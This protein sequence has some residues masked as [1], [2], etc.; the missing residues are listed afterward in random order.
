MEN[1]ARKKSGFMFGS[2]KPK[3][4]LKAGVA[5][6][7]TRHGKMKFFDEGGTTL[8]ERESKYIDP[9]KLEDEAND[10]GDFEVNLDKEKTKRRTNLS[11]F[12]AAFAASRARGEQE[13]KY[14]GDAKKKEGKY[15][16]AMKGE[17]KKEESPR[18]PAPA[19]A[20]PRPTAPAAARPAA[21]AAAAPIPAP[22]PATPTRSVVGQAQTPRGPEAI[23]QYNMPAQTPAAA[24]AENARLVANEQSRRQRNAAALA[25]PAKVATGY[26]PQERKTDF[27]RM[28]EIEGR[29]D[30]QRSTQSRVNKPHDF[31][32]SMAARQ[33]L[34]SPE[35]R[36]QLGAENTFL[37]N[38]YNMVGQP[39]NSATQPQYAK[40]GRVKKMAMGGLGSMG[41][42]QMGG[43]P[44]SLGSMQ[45]QP[46]MGG[47]MG[48][49]GALGG[50]GAASPIKGV[51]SMGGG[52]GAADSQMLSQ[53]GG[54][55]ANPMQQPMGGM[56]R[57][58]MG[59]GMMGRPNMGGMQGGQSG[60]MQ[61]MAKGGKVGYSKMEKE[62]VAAMKKHGVP[63][64]F[65]K[66]EEKEAKGMNKGGMAC[67]GKMKYAKGG[68]I[69]KPYVPTAADRNEKAGGDQE[70]ENRSQTR[71]AGRGPMSRNAMK[72]KAYAKGGGVESKGKTKGTMIRMASGG[73]V[74]SRAD[75]IA[76]KGKTKC[77][78]C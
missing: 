34:M 67:G 43:M 55:P 20:A 68:A 49:A 47:G 60:G 1:Q 54:G 2:K 22:R 17:G 76:S 41:G 25:A 9:T 15:S 58:P 71:G 30:S 61:A 66:Q 52:M 36:Y 28:R 32:G 21:P 44:R 13:F 24:K 39:E 74:S 33:F 42:G 8:A 53:Y 64:K 75:G 46:P 16:T 63:K 19:A 78:I 65:I 31:L 73:M 62:H 12:G 48:A 14:R 38:K 35:Q 57:P 11:E 59:G 37:R 70:M 26:T 18:R 6:P 29:L 69:K 50:L 40:G 45:Q 27:A 5:N 72:P 7:K 56:N 51:G 3:G 4:N 10:R 23:T 77:K